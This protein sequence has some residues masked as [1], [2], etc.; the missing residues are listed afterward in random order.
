LKSIIGIFIGA[1]LSA[2]LRRWLCLTLNSY[3][4][5]IPPGTL[6]ANGRAGE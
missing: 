3:F 4:P 6:A 2:L 5:S 1:G